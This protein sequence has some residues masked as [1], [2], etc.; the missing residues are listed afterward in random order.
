M[1]I[2]IISDGPFGDRAFENIKI[3]FPDTSLYYIDE[4]D[5]GVILD[6]YDF[7]SDV[8]SAINSSDLLI[9]YIRHPDIILELCYFAK[10]TII[11]IFRG[12][13]LLNQ[14]HDINPDTIM[15]SSM[16]SIE[17]NTGIPIID[18]FSKEFGKP[19]YEINFDKD[20]DTIKNIT[21][22]RESPC[23]A[24]RRSLV[25]LENQII[26]PKKIDEFAMYVIHECR[27]SV[28]YRLAQEETASAA[29]YNHIF[30]F[31]QDM[32]KIKPELFEKNGLLYGYEEEKLD[33]VNKQML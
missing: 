17:P 1:K 25:F 19:I 8:E 20:S 11:A 22:K 23:G 14:A 5:R 16:C 12:S 21:I 10:P 31:L 9:S 32:K 2:T 24:T 30:P 29:A 33:A 6:E 15:P 27:E 4:V 18:E 13:G 7:N 26:S 3:K 28:A